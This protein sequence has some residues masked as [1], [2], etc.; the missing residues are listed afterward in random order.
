[1][2]VLITLRSSRTAPAALMSLV[3]VLTGCGAQARFDGTRQVSAATLEA[4]AR[5]PLASWREHAR[6]ADLVDAA[7][8]MRER[9]DRLGY[10]WAEVEPSE[11]AAG[12]RDRLP[13]FAVREGPRVT[14]SGAT[15]G[16]DTG[17]PAYQ[18]IKSAGFGEWL[19]TA[20]IREAPGRVLRALR[21]AGH[22][23]AEVQPTQVRWNEARD[24]AHLHL[25]VAAGPRFIVAG[26]DLVV[27]GDP[28]L[29]AEMLPLLDKPGTVCHPRLVSE[30]AARLR[31]HL[32]DRG[33][34]H[35]IV[36]PTTRSD[37]QRATLSLHLE[38]TPGA[39]QTVA[40]LT[41][42]GGRR[43]ARSFVE[44]H[45]REVVPGKPLSQSALDAALSSLTL[46][47]LYR[48]VQVETAEGEPTPDGSVPVQVKVLLA[49]DP[50]KR[51]DLSV[52]YGSY[53]QLRGGAEYVDDHL[54]GRGLRFNL[55]GKA[56]LKGW[57]AET[58]LQ[59]PYLLGPGRRIGLEL[60]YSER[61]EPAYSHHEGS[62]ILGVSQK[63]KPLFDPVP[64]ELRG[65]YELR[66]S[67]DFDIGAPLPG[68]E[69][70]GEYTTSAV[71]LTLRRDSRTPKQIDPEAGTY[72]QLG[73]LVSA[74]PL[75][76]EVE[77]V[78]LGA[79][80]AGYLS[81]EPWLVVSAQIA[82]TT[83]EPLDGGSLPIGERLFLGG[84][85]TVRSFTKDDLGPRDADGTPVGG[86]TR[87]AA[88]LELRLR[89]FRYRA[90][91][92]ATFYDVGMVD[93][94]A[95]HISGPAGHAIGA[96]L[97]Y[98]TPVGPIRVDY[99]YNPGDRMG[100]DHP[101]ALHVAVGFAF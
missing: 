74:K 45:L 54:F 38:V 60:A 14:L 8:A 68:E 93:E 4:A 26:E 29:R 42:V 72:A 35:A 63:A 96:G 13:R 6:H 31:S 52:G 27:I 9:L 12:D 55:G 66:R 11:P 97:R 18:L 37:E 34:R 21:Q 92:I 51:V 71:G 53:E 41:V 2:S 15:A 94:E 47:G 80:L 40:G 10:V 16:G 56:S 64:Y 57:G 84:D 32:A 88:N 20:G 58:G 82:A 98:R 62:L 81:P 67:E 89:P 46:T 101:W 91:E 83:R 17:L 99:G 44:H 61:E 19:T 76:A 70:A 28:A 22:L 69:R 33:Y 77:F 95:W 59:D 36:T 30:V 3:L 79:A 25:Q 85:D 90:F 86:L 24:A 49:E 73:T 43:T 5:R 23:R 65:T 7:A 48:R 75:G 50:T 100:A 1:M 87:A 39:R 78:E